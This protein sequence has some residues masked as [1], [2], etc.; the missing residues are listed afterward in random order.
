[1]GSTI[2]LCER[3]SETSTAEFPS[4]KFKRL[5]LGHSRKNVPKGTPIKRDVFEMS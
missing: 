1:L 4:F 5:C 2:T 3:S